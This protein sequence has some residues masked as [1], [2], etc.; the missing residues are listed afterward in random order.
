MIVRNNHGG[1]S[2]KKKKGKPQCFNY[3]EW[4]HIKTY[5]PMYNK[6]DGAANIVTLASGCDN[7][8]EV[9][10]PIL[11]D[12]NL[13]SDH[14]WLCLALA[15]LKKKICERGLSLGWKTMINDWAMAV[16]VHCFLTGDVDIGE[17]EL[18]VETCVLRREET[19][20]RDCHP[21]RS[22]GCSGRPWR[23]QVTTRR[24]RYVPNSC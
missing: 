9:Q 7:T 17:V 2:I 13:R 12:K 20:A 23:E 16:L 4:G 8:Y 10:S 18:L 5:Y 22:S 3:K 14:N 24:H 19:T 1:K 15:L 21:R 11:Q 6:T